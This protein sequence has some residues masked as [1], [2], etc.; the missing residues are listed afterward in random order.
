[1]GQTKA[2][3]NTVSKACAYGDFDKLREYVEA[4]P[5]CVTQPDE[6]GYTPLQ[7]AALNNRVAEAT[8][9]L[10]HGALVNAQDHTGQ[11]ALH[12]AAVRGS[13]PVI[14]ALLRHG[15]DVELRDHRGYT[16]AHVAAQVR[17]GPSEDNECVTSNCC[18][19]LLRHVSYPLKGSTFLM[20]RPLHPA[21]CLW[22]LWL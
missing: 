18:S 20:C 10:S 7:W 13:L 21:S 12:W 17:T 14:E 2:E 15:A 16:L 19:C 8:F 11:S 6:S 1:M 3:I 5:S 4:D 22:W 9:L